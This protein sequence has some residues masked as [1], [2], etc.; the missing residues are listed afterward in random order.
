MGFGGAKGFWYS[1]V[2]GVRNGFAEAGAVFRCMD[3][4]TSALGEFTHALTRVVV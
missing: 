2:S 4:S 3:V 1:A